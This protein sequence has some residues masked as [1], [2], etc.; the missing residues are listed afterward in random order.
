MSIMMVAAF[1]L[2][3]VLSF[4]V[5]YALTIAASAALFTVGDVPMMAVVQ[6]MF[7]PTQSFPM[8]AIPFFVMAGDLMM[9]GRLGHAL[10]EFATDLVS[11]FRGGHAQVS[12]LGSTLFGGVSGSAVADATALG[13]V[14]IPWQKK[15]GYP[16]AF[17]GATI[18]AASTIDI[19][20]PPSIPLILYSLV[21]SASIGALFYAGILPGLALA[22]GF[23][24]V[25]NISARLRGF[26]Y[27]KHP[28]RWGVMAKRALYASPALL[29]PV[30]VLLALR[31]GVATPT[32]ISTIAVVYAMLCASLIYRDLTIKRVYHAMLAAGV[33]TGV[34]MLLIM[35]SS[36]VGW[37]LTMDQIP[38]A[39]VTWAKQFV[40]SQAAMLM[41]INLVLLV[42]GMF[43]DLPAAIL[44]LGP[45]LVP[46]AQNFGIDLVQLGIVVVINLAIGLYTPPVGTTLFIGATLAKARIGDVVKEL[47]P[48]YFVAVLVL[49]LFTYVPA[50]TL[51]G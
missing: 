41:L 28:L 34:V 22:V 47:I 50:L 25:C 21:S 33:A 44:L 15:V 14:L 4:P 8:I 5:A 43:L 9:A 26:P 39:I 40:H 3:M 1:V 30:F 27:E 31:F 6:Q 37:M 45:L 48:F 7:S 24:A 17:C 18:A 49:L 11:R 16:P 13:S 42:M 35:S 38:E 23:L 46:L 2:L 20:I 19:L 32:E 51:R 36:L 12:V 10:I 29:M